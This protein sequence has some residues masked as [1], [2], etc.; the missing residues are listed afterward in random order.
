MKENPEVQAVFDAL[1]Q[2]EEVTPERMAVLG[3]HLSAVRQSNRD[4]VG[5]LQ[6]HGTGIDPTSVLLTRLNVMA[7]VLFGP[8]RYG[9]DGRPSEATPQRLAFEIQYEEG[10]NEILRKSQGEAARQT[11]LRGVPG[12]DPN[13]RKG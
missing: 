2:G 4:L 10:M 9:E 13:G 3:K 6:Q 8:L 11:L 1:A 5:V 12:V 7:D